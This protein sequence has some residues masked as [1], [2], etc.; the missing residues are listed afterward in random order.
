M[1]HAK[2]RWRGQARLHAV[3]RMVPRGAVVADL[4]SDHGILP[5]L[6]LLTGRARRCIATERDE[7]ALSRAL[8][9]PAGHPLSGALEFRAGDGL[10]ALRPGDGVEVVTIAGLGGRSI[11]RIL[12]SPHAPHLALRRV[13]LQPQAQWGELRRWLVQRGWRIAEEQLLRERGRVYLVVAAEPGRTGSGLD[14][15][16]L[17]HDEVLEAG[18]CLVRSCDPEVSRFWHRE[19]KRHETVLQRVPPGPGRDEA[20][21]QRDLALRILDA[22]P[23]VEF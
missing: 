23:A 10:R 1:R 4:G 3:A 21:R 16:T 6:L 11:A 5:R 22:L 8:R 20:L 7:R 13:V 18:P 9:F 17:T 19:L 15:P 14:H 2:T 12:G